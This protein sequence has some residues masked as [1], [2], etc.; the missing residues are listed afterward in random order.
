MNVYTLTTVIPTNY[1]ARATG[2]QGLI[3]T[4]TTNVTV[5]AVQYQRQGI[6]TTYTN[7][8]AYNWLNSPD[9]VSYSLTITNFPSGTYSNFE[10]YLMLVEG[11]VG[12]EPNPDW[13]EYDVVLFT[14]QNR[15]DGTAFANL[16]YKVNGGNDNSMFYG[17]GNL[18]TISN[19]SPLG[20]WTVTFTNNDYVT[21]TTPTGNTLSTN[22]AFGD[23][24]LYFV[25]PLSVYVG[26]QANDSNNVGQA[27]VYSRFEIASNGV[28]LLTED[29]TAPSLDP[30]KWAVAAEDPAGILYVPLG[31]VFEVSWSL[32]DG[33]FYLQASHDMGNPGSWYDP[34]IPKAI[35][36]GRGAIFVTPAMARTNTF[37]RLF[38]P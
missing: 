4:T 17:S 13:V 28:P 14:V 19:V 26:A 23:A 2:P 10:S 11:P 38:H 34:G 27:S 37:F 31:A 29:F 35:H 16:Q 30:A 25:N 1:I 18:G 15:N 32:P 9:P 21:V 3:V 22:L 5:D 8:P 33:G 20:T 12:T 36:N 24:A 6:R 7:T